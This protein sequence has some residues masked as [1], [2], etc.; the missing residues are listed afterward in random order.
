V[1]LALWQWVLGAGCAFLVGVAK[2]GVPGLGILVVPTM[3]Y[4]VGSA[5]LAPGAL[6]PLLCVADA[7]AVWYYRRHADVWALLEL[8]PWVVVGMIGGWYVLRVVSEQGSDGERWLR[9]MVGAIVLVMVAAHL[10]RKRSGNDAAV[11]RHWGRA[12]LYGIIAGFAT[13]VANAAGPV[14]NLY[15]LSMALPKDQ[16]MGTG[17]WYFLI[18]NLAKIPIYATYDDPMITHATLVFDAC[19]VPAVIVGALCGRTLYAHVPQKAFEWSVF[20]LAA[21][22]ALSLLIPRS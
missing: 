14:M 2:T 15:L 18:I 7:F 22:G 8:L 1:T 9:T 3:V 21:V 5:W 4:V 19:L 6:L 13:T 20:A 11:A 16:F 12:A 17:A 10:A